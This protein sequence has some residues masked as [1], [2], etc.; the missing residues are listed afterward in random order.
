MGS[1][2]NPN[3]HRAALRRDPIFPILDGLRGG[4]PERND[5]RQAAIDE[6]LD[7]MMLDL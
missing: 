2:G 5:D 7:I 3:A 1:C 4:A 6:F